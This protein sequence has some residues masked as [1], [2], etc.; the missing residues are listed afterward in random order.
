M[1][2]FCIKGISCYHGN[3]IFDVMFN[4]ILAFLEFVSI[5]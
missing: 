2:K 4:Q 3:P 5:N 1:E